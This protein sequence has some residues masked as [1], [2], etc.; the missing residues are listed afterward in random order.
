MSLRYRVERLIIVHLKH[1]GTWRSHVTSIASKV[2][3]WIVEKVWAQLMHFRSCNL[4]FK[5]KSYGLWKVWTSM[6]KKTRLNIKPTYFQTLHILST[7]IVALTLVTNPT[8]HQTLTWKNR[9]CIVLVF[10]SWPSCIMLVLNFWPSCIAHL[11]Y[12][13][14]SC[15]SLQLLALSH[16]VVF[17]FLAFL[18]CS[19]TLN[20][21]AL[22]CFFILGLLV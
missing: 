10:N 7:N 14:P 11:L 9:S 3:I 18:C 1:V 4:D 16:C 13:W 21:F 12:S 2:E 8:Y 5:H 20:P 6:P 17:L 15:A 19:S 22:H